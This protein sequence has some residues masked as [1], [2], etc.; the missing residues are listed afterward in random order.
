MGERENLIEIS[1]QYIE[2]AKDRYDSAKILFREGKFADCISRSY[3]AVYT[4][5]KAILL[6]IGEQPKTHSGLI[7]LF[8]LKMVKEKKLDSKY[9]RILSSLFEARQTCDYE[10]LIWVDK[11]ESEKYVKLTGEFLEKIDELFKEYSL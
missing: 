7:Q 10:P 5:A 11:D 9:A 2:R 8:G 1:R 6:L 4:G 3:Y